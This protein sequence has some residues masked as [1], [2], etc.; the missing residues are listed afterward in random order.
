MLLWV[1]IGEDQ[2]YEGRRA[3]RHIPASAFGTRIAAG[4]LSTEREYQRPAEA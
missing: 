1:F 4:Q 3:L 2:R